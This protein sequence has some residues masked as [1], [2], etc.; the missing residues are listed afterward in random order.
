MLRATIDQNGHQR[1]LKSV[2]QLEVTYTDA[3]RWEEQKVE[4]TLD[5]IREEMG[6]RIYNSD[7]WPLFGIGVTKAHNRT[8]LHFSMDF[9]IADW[10]SIWLLLSEF[11]ALYAEPG[12]QLPD[13]N[14]SFRDYLLAE[15]SFR[16]TPTYSG[17]KDY[18]LR[19]VDNLP[20]APDLPLNRQQD[21]RRYCQLFCVNFS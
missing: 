3:S 12:R 11:E 4:A 18:W 7:R 14:L 21:N 20:P 15:R 1:V 13:L 8:V 9:L 17:D 6:H 16:E 10:A 19:R 5:E 2:P